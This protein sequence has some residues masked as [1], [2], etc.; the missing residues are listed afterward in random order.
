MRSS[1]KTV[2]TEGSQVGCKEIPSTEYFLKKK[3]YK[4]SRP[5]HPKRGIKPSGYPRQHSKLPY[6]IRNDLLIIMTFDWNCS[7]IKSEQT[8][9]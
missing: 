6:P 4:S 9:I 3:D 5:Q 2:D 1:A 7:S 8:V